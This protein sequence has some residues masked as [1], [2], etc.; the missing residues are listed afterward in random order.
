MRRIAFDCESHL[1][2]RG[3]KFPRLVCVSFA[4]GANTQ[5]LDRIVG[6]RLVLEYLANP[7]IVLVGHNTAFDL[8]LICAEAI[9]LARDPQT[10]I[11][12][13]TEHEIIKRIFVAYRDNRI[14]DTM[15]RA[16]LISIA[17]GD[18][19][20]IDGQQRVKEL[21]LDK[22]A[23]K[24][25]G[26][27]LQ[28]QDTW[29][30]H[31]AYLDGV[32]IFATPGHIQGFQF[33]DGTYESWPQEAI[34][35]SILDSRVTWDLDAKLTSWVI[36][37]GMISGEVPD[38]YPQA[39]AAWVLHLIAG[40]GVMV[41]PQSVIDLKT[42]LL[43]EQKK[44]H[45]VLD[46]Y[47]IFKKAKDGSY[48]RT[49]KGAIA[50]DQKRLQELITAG[51]AQRG[52]TPPQTTRGASTSADV[53]RESGHVA[54]VAFADVANT[55]KLLSTYVPILEIGITG[56]PITSDPNV[57]VA[58]GRTSWTKPNWQNPPTK[59]NIRDCVVPRAGTVFVSADL[60]TVELRA[61]AQACLLIVGRSEMA[62][63]LKRGEDLHLALAADILG[64]D[65][66]T[67]E[68]R[69]LAGDPIISEARQTAKKA[70]FSFPG[71]AGAEKVSLI[72]E[73]D[74]Q[75][76]AFMPDG[77]TPDRPAAKKRAQVLKDAWFR[78]WPEMRAYLRHA[79]DVCGDYGSNS[80]EQP[81][82]GRIRGGL[83]YCSCANTYFQGMVADGTKLALWELAW[84]CYVD[85]SSILYGSRIVLFLHD[86]VI[87]EVPESIIH[88]A[89]NEI[90][91]ILTQQVAKVIPDIPIT[92]QAIAFR[93]WYKG[94]KRVVGNDNRLIP[95]KPEY[96]HSIDPITQKKKTKTKWIPDQ[97][98]RKVAA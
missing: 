32:P 92:S 18:Y 5:L 95:C 39:R 74:G 10:A 4:E 56:T 24:W 72:Y 93:R 59:G 22:L 86:E 46:A 87:L 58:S 15:I 66:K 76:L 2:R 19:Q 69:Y 88:E 48:K 55:D 64:L 81:Y 54:C 7:D 12:V 79:G 77:V 52:E 65:Y 84:A 33:P 26:V 60:D 27:V 44:H 35:Y 6:T 62:E 21:G 67:A 13:P 53:A 1:L 50:K 45:S 71:G 43:I 30:L 42:S 91:R 47:G 94:A 68:S 82:S 96:T 78:K 37:E 38:A 85:E 29:R 20:E 31:Y 57:L 75:C 90:V 17:T 16:M 61:L 40:W 41:D 51:F 70:N 63:A 49:K 97:I 28:K 34:D 25:L 89:G 36:S 3:M 23:N 9:C 73:Q 11:L 98:P 8:G 14:V 80:I 83:D